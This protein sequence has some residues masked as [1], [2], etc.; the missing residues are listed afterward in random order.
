M[1]QRECNANE[2]MR[3]KLF[4]SETPAFGQRSRMRNGAGKFA[5]PVTN[6][7]HLDDDRAQQT[8]LTDPYFVR[9]TTNCNGVL[10]RPPPER[11]VMSPSLP[12]GTARRTYAADPPRIA[13]SVFTP[14]PRLV[15]RSG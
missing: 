8:R 6:L 2:Q 11:N 13:K 1:G 12:A 9:T 10:G 4:Y 7:I 5:G 14:S 3:L 15:T